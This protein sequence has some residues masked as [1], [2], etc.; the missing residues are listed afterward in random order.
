MKTLLPFFVGF[1]LFP[2]NSPSELDQL[3]AG[4]QAKYQRLGSLQSD[5]TQSYAAP[6]ERLRHESG[7]LQIKKPGKMRWDYNAPEAK[8]YVADGKVMFEYIPAQRVVTRTNVKDSND[9]RTPFLFLLGRGNLRRDFA[10]IEFAS[11]APVR[12]GNRVLRM[13]PKQ[14]SDLREVFLE[15]DPKSF[16]LTRISFLRTGNVRIDFLLSN[17]QENINLPDTLFSFKP[18]AGVSVRQQ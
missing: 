18:P 8:T 3:V 7:R 14:A 17:V 10:R 15:I 6:G 1:F 16:T 12:A 4:L 13:L 2:Y 11:E 9:W 5:F